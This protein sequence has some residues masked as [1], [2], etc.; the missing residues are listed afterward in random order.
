MK[1]RDYIRENRVELKGLLYA[2]P[3]IK[4]SNANKAEF[5]RITVKTTVKNHKNEDV[6]YFNSLTIW[7]KEQVQV[8]KGMKKDSG[9]SIVGRLVDKKIEENG[10]KRSIID[11]YVLEV[12]ELEGSFEHI[13][14]VE[15]YGRSVSKPDIKKTANNFIV[16]NGTIA[17]GNKKSKNKEGNPDF[18]K[19]S[20]FGDVATG[21]K[22]IEKGKWTECEAIIK[23][24]NYTNREGKTIY[25]TE[26]IATY[27]AEKVWEDRETFSSTQQQH[28]QQDADDIVGNINFDI[29]DM[30]PVG[31]GDNPFL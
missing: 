3:M 9:I 18:L 23:N 19:V 30:M 13:N 7:N 16:G 12:K 14:F 25:F 4:V 31:D 15:L 17:V 5:A 1:K 29:E 26:L 10:K 20:L 22:D 2:D 21:A 8:L 11:I 6:T 24:S 28:Q 27:F